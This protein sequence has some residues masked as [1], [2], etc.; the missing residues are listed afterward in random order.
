MTTND[1]LAL[2]KSRYE[3]VYTEAINLIEG[4]QNSSQSKSSFPME[5]IKALRDDLESFALYNKSGLASRGTINFREVI[6]VYSKQQKSL[7]K[8]R[9]KF[10][11]EDLGQEKI[12]SELL[13]DSF[14]IYNCIPILIERVINQ[15]LSNAYK[16]ATPQSEIK[17]IRSIQDS[18]ICFQNIGPTLEEGEI[19]RLKEKGYRGMHTESFLGEGQGLWLAE[20]AIELHTKFIAPISFTLYSET[21]SKFNKDSIPY[22]DFKAKLRFDKQYFHKS[23]SDVNS[24]PMD[25]EIYLDAYIHDIWELLKR[26]HRSIKKLTMQFKEFIPLKILLEDLWIFTDIIKYID[27]LTQKD[28]E[29]ESYFFGEEI[30]LNPNEVFQN[31]LRNLIAYKYPNFQLSMIGTLCKQ[32][33]VPSGFYRLLSGF[34]NL[35]LSKISINT[36]RSIIFDINTID[37]E[38]GEGDVNKSFLDALNSP[39][40]NF[41]DI[42]GDELEKCL[43]AFYLKFFKMTGCDIEITSEKIRL[44]LPQ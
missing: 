4:I 14:T 3:T 38:L 28:R 12:T 5:T 39:L 9:I 24:I 25:G 6:L 22:A 10:W 2:L 15:L 18:S 32:I 13:T 23:N 17:I 36:E 34:L 42:S 37:I 11:I 33:S 44:T 27:D 1:L 19:D 30:L 7:K 29:E 8:V 40:S 31:Q 41:E 21:N 26:L 20:N 35:L 16:Y 43:P